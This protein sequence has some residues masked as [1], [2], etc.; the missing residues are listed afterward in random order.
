MRMIEAAVH[1]P[2]P[3]TP[4]IAL[5]TEPWTFPTSFSSSRAFSKCFPCHPYPVANLTRTLIPS[6]PNTIPFKPVL[7]FS[8]A[9]LRS[10]PLPFSLVACLA[11]PP[12]I[13]A[14]S[15][16]ILLIYCHPAYLHPPF[17]NVLFFTPPYSNSRSGLHY[18]THILALFP[19]GFPTIILPPTD[20]SHFS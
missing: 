6:L 17:H 3:Q 10:S 18:L 4:L 15:T 11:L 16:P 2:R 12:V 8:V 14:P 9:L 7:V 19:P 13:L 1:R 20:C 5:F